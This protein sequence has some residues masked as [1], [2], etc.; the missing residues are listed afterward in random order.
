MQSVILVVCLATM[1]SKRSSLDLIR[2]RLSQYSLFSSVRPEL[3]HIIAV[4]YNEQARRALTGWLEAG[5]KLD[6]NL[7]LLHSKCRRLA[8]STVIGMHKLSTQGVVGVLIVV[9]I[10]RELV[11]PLQG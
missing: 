3:Q 10:R 5:R 4:L 1:G 8:F 7:D 9:K 2:Y 6:R 11:L